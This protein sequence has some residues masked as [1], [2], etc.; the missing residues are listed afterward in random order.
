MINDKSK[1]KETAKHAPKKMPEV[2][3]SGKLESAKP[4]ENQA[5]NKFAHKLNKEETY[6]SKKN[7]VRESESSDSYG[8]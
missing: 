4:K 1:K 3:R 5:P 8:D 6:G 2:S 7:D